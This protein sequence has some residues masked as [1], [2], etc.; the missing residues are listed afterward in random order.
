MTIN[1]DTFNQI[2]EL[3]VAIT[4]Q[5][6]YT[7]DS[8]K[9]VKFFVDEGV[10][11][12]LLWIPYLVLTHESIDPP[13]EVAQTLAS[14]CVYSPEP[15]VLFPS[16]KLHKDIVKTPP[17]D[18]VE[19]DSSKVRNL[20][21]ETDAAGSKSKQSGSSVP[22]K[23]V[24]LAQILSAYNYTS[25]TSLQ[26]IK[27][28]LTQLC[29]TAFAFL[30]MLPRYY[31]KASEQ[32]PDV[33]SLPE[34]CGKI[35][36]LIEPGLLATLFQA[37][38]KQPKWLIFMTEGGC[39][40]TNV[41]ISGLLYLEVENLLPVLKAELS[42]SLLGVIYHAF[43]SYQLLVQ[44]GKLDKRKTG[45]VLRR[46]PTQSSD[47]MAETIIKN[48]DFLQQKPCWYSIAPICNPDVAA[49]FSI[50]KQPAVSKTFLLIIKWLDKQ[51]EVNLER[52][53]MKLSSRE[54]KEGSYGYECYRKC[55]AYE[56]VRPTR[57][58]KIDDIE[59]D[60]EASDEGE[61]RLR[62]SKGRKGRKHSPSTS[63]SSS[64]TS[65]SSSPDESSGGRPGAVLTHA[66]LI[67]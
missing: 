21:I 15:T 51:Q 10:K 33:V 23:R 22:A 47:A 9:N 24:S 54:L 36:Q 27:V 18:L 32:N 38:I 25:P 60:L 13:P 6:P 37:F 4:R 41:A 43:T 52:L 14:L 55:L 28:T 2:S 42:F 65:R 8:W 67:R 57:K 59:I 50:A 49:D 19:W 45:E 35:N 62:K 48:K 17:C 64:S 66:Y 56:T 11:R 58:V 3:D 46:I 30:F 5:S 16:D 29:H 39:I 20:F 31:R 40:T 12:D 61:S 34:K 1:D 53:V 7:D 44:V 63:S 26:D